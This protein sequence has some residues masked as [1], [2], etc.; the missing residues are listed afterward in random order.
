MPLDSDALAGLPARSP[1]HLV[2]S[3]TKAPEN[4]SL[5]RRQRGFGS[6]RAPS[7]SFARLRDAPGGHAGR[8][9]TLGLDVPLVQL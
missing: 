3:L 8:A 2:P 7:G 1:A 4:R 5:L 9:W 6:K